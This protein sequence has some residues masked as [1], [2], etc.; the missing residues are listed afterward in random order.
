MFCK[1]VKQVIANRSTL[2]PG[3]DL[4]SFNGLFSMRVLQYGIDNE[5]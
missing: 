4:S 2:I 3:K 5:L 1:I